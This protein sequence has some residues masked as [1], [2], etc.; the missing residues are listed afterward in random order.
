[1]LARIP[2][3]R[4]LAK[5]WTTAVTDEIL[6]SPVRA[7]LTQT[8]RRAGSD[9]RIVGFTAPGDR[10]GKTSVAMAYAVAA[11]RRG[12]RVLLIDADAGKVSSLGVERAGIAGAVPIIRSPSGMSLNSLLK[13]DAPMELL[14]QV[15][16][17]GVAVVSAAITPE[18]ADILALRLNSVLKDALTRADQIVVNCPPITNNDGQLLIAQLPTVMVVVRSGSRTSDFI[19]TLNRL[20]SLGVDILGVLFNY[21]GRS[22]AQRSGGWWDEVDQE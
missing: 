16:V 11:A 5:R 6:G 2:K 9:V 7:A 3:S 13:G 12:R 10:H 20:K 21:D 1:M 22:H 19:N 18:T 15:P 4:R 8:E 17:G 14:S